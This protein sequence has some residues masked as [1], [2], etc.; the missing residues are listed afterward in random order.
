M[1][2]SGSGR[3]DILALEIGVV[4]LSVGEGEWLVCDDGGGRLDELSRSCSDIEVVSASEIPPMPSSLANCC[5]GSESS[6]A[7]VESCRLR[8]LCWICVSLNGL[9]SRGRASSGGVL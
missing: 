7:S 3:L 9:F 4:G 6:S 2:V 1:I 8:I 5:A